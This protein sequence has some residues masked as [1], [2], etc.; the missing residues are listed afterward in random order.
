MKIFIST[1]STYAKFIDPKSD[2]FVEWFDGSKVCL[3]RKRPLRLFRGITEYREVRHPSSSL[4][5]F[6]TTDLNIARAYAG[7]N[8]EVQELYASIKYPLCL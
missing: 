8:G 2:A 6:M 4:G 3:N 1:G 7:T 5:I